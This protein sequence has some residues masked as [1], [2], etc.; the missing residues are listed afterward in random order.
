VSL[1]LLR[2]RYGRRDD[3]PLPSA[4]NFFSFYSTFSVL[5]LNNPTS[6][7]SDHFAASIFRVS[8]KTDPIQTKAA[9]FTN[10]TEDCD[11]KTLAQL[12]T[13]ELLKRTLGNGLG[14]LDATVCEGLTI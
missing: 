12:R 8:E 13:I 10:H 6:D 9:Q 7:V 5:G 14:K 1:L 2:R 4:L 11:W 3:D